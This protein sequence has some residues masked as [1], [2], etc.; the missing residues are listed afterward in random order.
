MG[1]V[2]EREHMV[3]KM[4]TETLPLFAEKLKGA[5][6]VRE[7]GWNARAR[8]RR[9][10]I[11]SAITLALLLV[12]YSFCWWQDSVQVAGFDR[13]ITHPMQIEGQLYCPA[14]ALFAPAKVLGGSSGS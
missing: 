6:V 12:G 4:I 1:V 11:A 13:C 7:Q 9:Y 2:V 14:G 10:A 3:Q 8:D 5:L